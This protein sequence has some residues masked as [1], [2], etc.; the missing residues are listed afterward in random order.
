[1]DDHTL[2][3]HKV[4]RE[5]LKAWYPI[6]A[7][8]NRRLV[9][10]DG[11]AGPGDYEG[12]EVGSPVI[13]MNTYREAYPAFEKQFSTGEMMFLFVENDP[14]RAERLDE[15][16]KKTTSLPLPGSIHVEVARG[17]FDAAMTRV[18]GGL[19][20]GMQLAPAFV[21]VDPFGVKDYPMALLGKLLKSGKVEL[22]ISFMY[23]FL[24][25]FKSTP[26]FDKHLTALYG[27][28]EW[29]AGLELSGETKK[30]FFFRLY[31]RQLK[32]AGAKHVLRFDLYRGG[33]LVY[34]LFFATQ[35]WKGSDVMKP[36]MWKVA[37]FGDFAFR[38]RDGSQLL[39]PGAEPDYTP[40]RDV[41]RAK[42]RGIGWVTVETVEEFVASDETDFHTGQYKKPVLVPLERETLIEVDP[43]S[44]KKA[45]TFP[46]GT[47]LRFL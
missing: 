9:F 7:S 38:G 8:F 20:P 11:F 17:D 42:F 30:V 43:A 27:T 41:M 16:V 6:M 40:L 45:R 39:L 10:V 14:A 18:L 26:E 1:M 22:Y 46:D 3:K 5:Y 32:V 47:K 37:P 36:A 24:D 12:G 31:E 13:A 19:K 44:R 23:E 33:R 35:H 15:I 21:M 2:G 34:A 28:E 25:R 29:K 4:L